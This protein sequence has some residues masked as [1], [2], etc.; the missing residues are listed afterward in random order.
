MNLFKVRWLASS[1]LLCMASYVRLNHC[2]ESDQFT[3]ALP[4]SLASVQVGQGVRRAETY[5]FPEFADRSDM[6]VPCG[7]VA[8]ETVMHAQQRICQTLH[9]NKYGPVKYAKVTRPHPSH[10]QC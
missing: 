5:I 4:L 1:V 6:T 3:H 8:D 10:L 9:N 7:T 2:H